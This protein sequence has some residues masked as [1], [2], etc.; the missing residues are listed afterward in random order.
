VRAITRDRRRPAIAADPVVVFA[1]GGS[2]G[3]LVPGMRLAEEIRRRRGEA[4]FLFLRGPRQIEGLVLEGA[5]G[6]TRRLK[7]LSAPRG[8]RGRVAF[9]VTLPA[10]LARSM[11][12]L[13][14][15][16]ADTVVGLGGYGAVPAVL[17]GRALGLKVVLL[18]QNARPG[19]ATRLLGPLAHAVCCAF[20]QTAGQFL[21]GRVTGNPV[22]RPPSDVDRDAAFRRFDLSPDRSTLLVVGGSQGARGLNRLVCDNLDSL[23]AVRESLQVLHLAGQADRT[24][25]ERAYSARGMRARVEAF[26]PDMPLAY[27]VADAVVSRAGGTTLAE[28]AVAG[29]PAVLV[30]YPHH[31]DRHQ[32]ANARLF[33]EAGAAFVLPEE[34]AQPAAFGR[35]VGRLVRDAAL[36]S[37]MG[38]A[39]AGLGRPDAARRIVEVMAN[40]REGGRPET[41]GS[42]GEERE[43]GRW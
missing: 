5:P 15:F 8:W 20:P 33:E 40:G 38:S 25:V 27:R 37:A 22:S 32:Y 36:R 43:V 31:R 10:L 13:R 28:L 16:D 26:V 29:L 42:P 35:T 41:P 1:G 3:H 12:I 19:L 2:G 34:S 14:Q 6:E 30:P 7:G 24:W 9:A 17:A 11:R 39:A 21:N 18:E 4:R 23:T